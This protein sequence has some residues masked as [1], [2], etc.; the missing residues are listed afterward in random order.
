MKEGKVLWRS[1]LLFVSLP[2]PVPH[3]DYLTEARRRTRKPR[4]RLNGRPAGVAGLAL[5]AKG[6]KKERSA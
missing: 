5:S 3:P 6:M 1:Q 4:L 2:T